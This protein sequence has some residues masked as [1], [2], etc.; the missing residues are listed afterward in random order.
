VGLNEH[1]MP[2]AISDREVLYLVRSFPRLSQTFILNELVQLQAL[3]ARLGVLSIV[4]ADEERTHAQLDAL[5]APVT[6][7]EDLPSGRLD[8]LRDHAA[9]LAR[10]PVRYART[11]LTH[12]RSAYRT[13]GYHS[14]ASGEAFDLAVRTARAVGLHRPARAARTRLHAHFAHDPALLALLI[15]D[16]TGT[17]YSFTGHARDLIQIPDEAL[18]ERVAR[19]E[20]VVTCCTMN[21]EL[22]RSVEPAA[23]ARI[24]LVHNGV[25]ISAFRPVERPEHEQVRV[26]SIGRLVDKKGFETLIDAVALARQ[27]G[28]DLA[29]DLYGEGPLRAELQARI[30]GHGLG[31]M[32]VLCGERTQQQIHDL[33]PTYDV[34]ALTPCVTDDGD[35]DGLPTVLVEAMACAL[36]VVTTDVA[37]IPD[38][39][40]DGRNG[41]LGPERDPRWTADALQ[42]LAG[43][44]ELRARL[45]AAA[46]RTVEERFDLD[47][48]VRRLA[49]L[50]AG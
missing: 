49:T 30:D 24:H 37:G 47:V 32:I 36:P 31:A 14:L 43:D 20:A 42:R 28:A 33:L 26:C 12:R 23:A 19:A 9:V 4:H 6:Y 45:G 17:A 44:A 2:H 7:L 50:L 16:L 21:V 41:L 3:G 27:A 35:R 15:H 22:L 25:D 11:A 29:L 1:E 8:R 48:T 13:E 18:A 5:H 34:F 10:H 39:V 40:E 38:L 46:R